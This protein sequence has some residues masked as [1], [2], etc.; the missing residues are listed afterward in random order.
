[1]DII[2]H[3]LT[4]IGEGKKS[5]KPASDSKSDMD[6]FQSVAK[7][8]IYADQQGWLNSCEIHRESMTANNWYDLIFV[9]NGLSYEGEQYL[10][11]LS[12]DDNV[13]SQTQEDI[14]EL[15]PNFMGLGVNLN[16]LLR[17]WKRRNS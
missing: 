7:V 2:K 9:Q 14:I 8:L 11:N 13:D 12:S 15:R 16:A 3:L 1:M 10:N 17:W 6:D 4:E 5:F